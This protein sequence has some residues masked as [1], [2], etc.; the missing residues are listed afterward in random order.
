M[1]KFIAAICMAVM[2]IVL[3]VTLAACGGGNI[4]GTYKFSSMKFK[5]GE[6][7]VTINVGEEFQGI[8]VT[9]DTY[10]LELKSDNTLSLSTLMAGPEAQ[11][12]GGTWEADGNT[13]SLVIDGS[14]AEATYSNGTLTVTTGEG[15]VNMQ[16]ILKK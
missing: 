13:V 12:L 1:K 5:D 7:E 10:I 8:T 16:L 3:V 9:E 4:A 11:T 14:E 6:T 15:G 2:A